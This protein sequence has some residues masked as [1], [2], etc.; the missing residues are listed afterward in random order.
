[1]AKTGIWRQQGKWDS[2]HRSS[3]CVCGCPPI[4][5]PASFLREAGE[6]SPPKEPVDDP[7]RCRAAGQHLRI[8]PAGRN[9]GV[10]VRPSRGER[11]QVRIPP[12]RRRPHH[13]GDAGAGQRLPQQSGCGSPR[14]AARADAAPARRHH[15]SAAGSLRQCRRRALPQLPLLRQPS[16]I[17]AVRQHLLA[18]RRWWRTASAWSSATFIPSRRR[19]GCS[20]PAWATARC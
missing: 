8:L 2:S 13:A 4:S 19:S 18:R 14:G 1:M 5:S 20:T 15:P 16:E 12:A 6:N 17:P 7:R 9:G 10:D 11:R 3:Q